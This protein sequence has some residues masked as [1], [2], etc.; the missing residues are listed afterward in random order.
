MIHIALPVLNELEW[1][2]LC[3]DSLS[4][5]RDTDFK[6]WA[7][8]NQPEEWS[9]DERYREISDANQSCLELLNAETA[10][11]IEI[12]DRCSPGSGWSARKAGVG[13]ARKTIMDRI[14]ENADETDLIVSLDADT[15]L[16]PTYLNQVAAAFREHPDRPALS[17]PYR[18]PL[19]NDELINRAMLRYEIYMRYYVLN[20]WRIRSPYAFTALGSAIALPVERYRQLG[21]ITPRSA[22]ED[23]YFLQKLA[24]HGRLIQALDAVVVPAT[25]RSVRVPVGTGQAIIAGCDGLHP[26]RYPLYDHRWFDAVG[27][28]TQLFGELHERNVETPLDDFLN[29]K[30]DGSDPW[31]RLRQNNPDRRRFIHACH[32]RVDGLRVLQY[33]KERYRADPCDDSG[34][35]QRWFEMRGEPSWADRIAT[36]GLQSMST[37]ALDALRDHLFELE[38]TER[39]RDAHEP[40][41]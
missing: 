19:T 24:K 6:L 41:L 30:L 29:Q 1:L 20:L 36:D 27:E 17:A 28:T 40:Q 10:I 22:A 32:E 23:F 35:L 16:P 9:D 37:D 5:Q 31:E 3:I 7:C 26:E 12:I 33:L 15:Q 13:Q 11:P 39:L 4:R 21:G 25:R 34:S 18:H 14:A 38:R 2:P 8:V